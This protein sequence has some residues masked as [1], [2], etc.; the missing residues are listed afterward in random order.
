MPTRRTPRRWA[1]KRVLTPAAIEAFERLQRARNKEEWREAHSALHDELRGRPW[2]W[3]I[4]ENPC[5]P[6]PF[7]VGT[8]AAGRWEQERA[9]NPGP[10]EL[11]RELERAVK[12]ARAATGDAGAPA[13]AQTPRR[14]RSHRSPR[15][16]SP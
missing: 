14:T 13:T 2:E 5:E 1:E 6:C 9:T 8:Y 3:P 15:N 4:V 16:L 11:W 10:I 12:A 7:P